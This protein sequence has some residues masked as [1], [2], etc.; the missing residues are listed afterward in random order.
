MGDFFFIGALLITLGFLGTFG[1]GGTTRFLFNASGGCPRSSLPIFIKSITLL[2]LRLGVFGN[3]IAK[4]T[5]LF[6]S[7]LPNLPYILLASFS[8]I[9]FFKFCCLFN[10]QFLTIFFLIW[11]AVI[12]LMIP[13]L[14]TDC[15]LFS[16]LFNFFLTS[17]TSLLMFMTF[18]YLFIHFLP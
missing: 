1:F 6:T 12:F 9:S 16:I 11:S 2:L 3:D 5:I 4:L 14:V 13:L 10:F 17:F 18:P 8:I 7:F 15:F